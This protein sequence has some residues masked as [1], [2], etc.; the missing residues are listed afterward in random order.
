[1]VLYKKHIQFIT[2]IDFYYMIKW[3]WHFDCIAIDINI[4]KLESHNLSLMTMWIE[5]DKYIDSDV[6]WLILMIYI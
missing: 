1:M 5:S 6:T 3:I 2:I 4:Y